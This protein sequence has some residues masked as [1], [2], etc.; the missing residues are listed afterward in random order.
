MSIRHAGIFNFKATVSA[1]QKHTFF[2]ALKTLEEINYL[3]NKI[4]IRVKSK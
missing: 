4:I 1:S 3:I 2:V